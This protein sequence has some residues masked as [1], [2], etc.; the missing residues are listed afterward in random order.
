L[1]TRDTLAYD[2]LILATGSSAQVPPMAGFGVE[3]SFVLRDA[4]DAMTIRDHMQRRGGKS[5]VVIGAGLLGLE[6][7]QALTQLGAQVRLLAKS[8]QLLDRQIDAA[9]SELLVAHLATR[10]IVVINKARALSLEHDGQGRLAEVVLADG[11]R[12]PADAVVVCAGSRANLDL[13]RS[14]GLAIGRGIT[15]DAH[16]RTSDRYVYAAGDVAE[17]EGISHGLWAVAMEQGE[18]AAV[19]ALGAPGGERVYRGHVPVTALKVSGIDVRSAG[20]LHGEVELT[21]HDAAQGVYRKLVIA[22]GKVVGA[23]LVG[24]PDESD[25]IV[26]AVRERAGVSTLGALL[27]QG[28]WRKRTRALAA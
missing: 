19:N 12:L 17:F 23:V 28:H 15:V 21:Q 14:A 10:G 2:R 24:S 13:A 1:A 3:G 18:I 27:Q 8:A 22:Q 20:E 11:R 4:D 6:A 9:A 5:A 25:D 26:Q 7:A 16:M